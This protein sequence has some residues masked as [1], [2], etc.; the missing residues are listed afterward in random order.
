M[1][2]VAPQQGNYEATHLDLIELKEIEGARF[3]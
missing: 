1:T 2:Q 3:R